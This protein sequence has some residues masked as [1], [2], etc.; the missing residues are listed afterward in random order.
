[1]EGHFE[2]RSVGR[3]ENIPP[4]V[5]LRGALSIFSVTARILFAMCVLD[6]GGSIGMENDRGL[7][8][9]SFFGPPGGGGRPPSLNEERNDL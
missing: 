5:T 4:T 9:R 3:R 7:A 8:P 1:M 2:G 6:G